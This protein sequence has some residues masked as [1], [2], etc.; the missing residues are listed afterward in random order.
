M[1]REA[2]I[3]DFLKKSGISTAGISLLKKVSLG[4]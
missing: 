4:N 3:P 1:I 2:E